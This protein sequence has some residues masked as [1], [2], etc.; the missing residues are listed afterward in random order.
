[1]RKAIILLTLFVIFALISCSNNTPTTG[2]TIV[3]SVASD[4]K[5][6]DANTLDNPPND[7]AAIL[8]QLYTLAKGDIEMYIFRIA[9]GKRYYIPPNAISNITDVFTYGEINSSGRIDYNSEFELSN[10]Y[11]PSWTLSTVMGV[12][13]NLNAGENDLIIFH[14]S[15]HGNDETGELV[16]T[17]EYDSA[18]ETVTNTDMLGVNNVI[19]T[20]C[21]YNTDAIKVMFLDSCYSGNFIKDGILSSTDRLVKKYKKDIYKGSSLLESLIGSFEVAFGSDSYG[22][23]G[24]YVLAASTDSQTAQDKL[25]MGESNQEYYGAF[26]FYLL[27]ALGFDTSAT[28]PAYTSNEITFCSLYD[29]IWQAFP[30]ST[31]KNQTPQ[32]TLSPMDVVL[33]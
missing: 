12:I 25:N 23:P 10:Y 7:Q 27:R 26:T 17:Y 24:L 6:T 21:N 16:T 29:Y 4:Y 13:E 19:A 2:R 1:M 28:M 3:I 14:Y 5:D 11:N 33:F 31:K 18:T 15:G 8:G 32:V 9:D 20:M 30:S 22:T